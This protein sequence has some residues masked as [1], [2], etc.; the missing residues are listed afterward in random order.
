MLDALLTLPTWL[1][2]ALA[3]G[4]GLAVSLAG[5]LWLGRYYR[6]LVQRQRLD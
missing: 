5:G 2:K 1:I 6:R 4:L 3:L